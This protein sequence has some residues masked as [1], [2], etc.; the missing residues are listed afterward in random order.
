MLSGL[1]GC[2]GAPPKPIELEKEKA[3]D[4]AN[5]GIRWFKKGCYSRAL[6]LF[7]D[8][9][10]INQSTD[11]LPGMAYDYNNIGM[12]ALNTGKLNE[13]REFFTLA[14]RIQRNPDNE[15][16]LSLSLSNLAAV[17]LKAKNPDQA[18]RHLEEAYQA[19]TRGKDKLQQAFVLNLMGHLYWQ[20]GLF[21]MANDYVSKAIA[22]YE[23]GDNKAGMA[24]ACHNLGLIRM[25]EGNYMEAQTLWVKSL[26]LDQE[27]LDYPGIAA[28]L[29][30]LARL[31][32][33]QERWS[34]AAEYAWRAFNV[35]Y[36]IGHKEKASLV[37]EILKKADEAGNL[38]SPI[39]DL[40]AKFQE[41][42]SPEFD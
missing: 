11:N 24:S 30:M 29:E 37:L 20:K 9:L 18:E 41:M 21:P 6:S 17:D 3:L 12:L 27:T 38:K 33:K 16:G 13:A 2:A 40:E 8:S 32:L 31:T 36:N 25:S 5:Q 34:E 23:A 26:E 42:T 39:A 10:R 7:E 14:A 1:P 22:I 4:Y 15:A 28:D 35:C 19:A